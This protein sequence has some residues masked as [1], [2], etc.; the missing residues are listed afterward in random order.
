M[1]LAVDQDMFTVNRQCVHCYTSVVGT[2]DRK[3]NGVN[4]QDVH[5][6][7]QGLKIDTYLAEITEEGEL[8]SVAL[9]KKLVLKPE[10]IYFCVKGSLAMVM[11][12]NGLMIGNTIEH[13]PVGLLERYCPLAKFEYIA[14]A[15]AEVIKISYEA[16]DRIFMKNDPQRIQ[17]L[18]TIL[19]YMTITNGGS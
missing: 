5:S 14:V 19:L 13:M 15:P 10:C 7:Y 12:D 6:Y 8:L 9:N 3:G 4:F 16:F 11:P 2:G 18:T 17:E 1:G